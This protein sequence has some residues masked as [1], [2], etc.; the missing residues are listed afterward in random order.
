MNIIYN[1]ILV[2]FVARTHAHI[3]FLYQL[4]H[5]RHSD[6]TVLEYVF[7]LKPKCYPPPNGLLVYV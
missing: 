4:A 1:G 3:L 6:F 2:G 5:D 7:H